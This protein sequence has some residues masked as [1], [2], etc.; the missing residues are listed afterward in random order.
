[1]LWQIPCILNVSWIQLL[2]RL[3]IKPSIF[4]CHAAVQW[5]DK[6]RA[7]AKLTIPTKTHNNCMIKTFF[8]CSITEV[9]VSQFCDVMVN[10]NGHIYICI[11]MYNLCNMYNDYMKR[12]TERWQKIWFKKSKFSF[13]FNRNTMFPLCLLE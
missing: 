6:W 12:G 3:Y 1:M 5:S 2:Q 4:V 7:E 9:F 11:Y 13:C 8:Q 10:W